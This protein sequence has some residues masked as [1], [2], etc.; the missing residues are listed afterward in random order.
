MFLLHKKLHP[1]TNNWIRRPRRGS[2]IPEAAPLTVPPTVGSLPLLRGARAG[3][4]A[5]VITAV[6][7]LDQSYCADLRHWHP[8]RPRVWRGA[9]FCADFRLP[10]RTRFL[11]RRLAVCVAARRQGRGG[12]RWFCEAR[13]WRGRPRVCHCRL[14]DIP[15]G[16]FARRLEHSSR[17]PLHQR[18]SWDKKIWNQKAEERIYSNC[19]LMSAH[20][21]LWSMK[22]PLHVRL[23]PTNVHW[24]P[25]HVH[26]QSRNVN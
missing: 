17:Q 11:P 22:R 5:A 20:C 7:M 12:R 24:S 16:V 8:P 2:L 19:P 21:P 26:L 3:C 4:R 15:R 23:S 1:A 18:R 14:L 6:G 13:R 25:L 10:S 9:A